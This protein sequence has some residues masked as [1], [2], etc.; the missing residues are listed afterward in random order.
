[1]I[2]NEVEI[3][4]GLDLGK[5]HHYACALTNQGH[6]V[7]AKA[8]PN[9]QDQL[10]KV[11]R[12]LQDRGRVLVVV[13]QPATIG[14]LAVAVAQDLGLEMA[15]L[16]GLKMPRLADLHPGKAKNDA[17]DAYIIAD[18]TRT[19]PTRCARSA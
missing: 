13:D 8:L 1:M 14:A 9:G 16:P 12:Q 11:Y 18:S 2:D 17:K 19:L 3:F 7:L 5:S 15:Y 4:L 6:Q 10:V